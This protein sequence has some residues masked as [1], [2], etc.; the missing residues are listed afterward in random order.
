M[1]EEKSRVIKFSSGE[2]DI[3]GIGA[4]FLE[5]FGNPE[6]I[7][8]DVPRGKS[9]IFIQLFENSPVKNYNDQ[10]VLVHFRPQYFYLSEIAGLLSSPQIKSQ[11]K[12]LAYV[13][14]QGCEDVGLFCAV[15]L[16]WQDGGWY[17]DA[18]KKS[19][20]C[21]NRTILTLHDFSWA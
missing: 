21:G 18:H 11:D 14:C 9:L 12:C 1:E 2:P 16:D 4:G 20:E 19:E 7:P 5:L 8:Q 15:T 17:I 6:V 10:D 3:S 13:I